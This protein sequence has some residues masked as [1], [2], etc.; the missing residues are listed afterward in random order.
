M[1]RTNPELSDC[2]QRSRTE[3]VPL[4][5]PA[6]YC[7][8]FSCKYYGV[9]GMGYVSVSGHVLVLPNN[10]FDAAMP[11]NAMHPTMFKSMKD[12]DEAPYVSE[13]VWEWSVVRLLDD[14]GRRLSYA[15]SPLK[16]HESDE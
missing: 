5:P 2:V 7:A 3:N 1:E 9:P 10:V 16:V 8:L 4:N 14:L 13:I 6:E 12:C 15:P 11:H